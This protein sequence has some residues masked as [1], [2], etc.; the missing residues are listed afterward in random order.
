M[1]TTSP[2]RLTIRA[3]LTLL[4]SG[5]LFA[6]GA[7]QLAAMY[8]IVRNSL[9]RGFPPDI[10][11]ADAFPRLQ[12]PPEVLTY[13]DGYRNG[14][15]RD[16]ITQSAIA[17][18]LIGVIASALGWWLA[19]RALAPIHQIATTA[20]RVSSGAL[21]ERIRLEGPRDELKEL[22]DT[23]D[24]M[25]D[26]LEHAFTSQQRFVAN[27]S[28]ELRTP[29]ATERAILE[30]ALAEPSASKDLRH[31][32]TQLLNVHTRS[33]R[34]IDG[35]LTLA[36]GDQ[37]HTLQPVD[38]ADLAASAAAVCGAEAAASEITVTT[39][40]EPAL[41]TGD[42]DLLDRLVTN[43]VQNAIRYNEPGG[44]VAV[45]TK[46]NR[47]Q[48]GQPQAELVVENTGLPVDQDDL[49][50][51]FEPFRRG[52]DRTGDGVGLGL[53]IVKAITTAHGGNVNAHSRPNDGGLLVT[54][55]MPSHE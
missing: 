38:L 28:H 9:S 15:L 51:L 33:E 55:A 20:E 35:L 43:L 40:L 25:L 24:A 37:P 22:A 18:V 4:Y 34:L 39:N 10:P 13:I 17:L 53:S 44:W 14:I 52:Q 16:L 1:N 3:R 11:G 31:I 30:V 47:Q 2:T 42:P 21:T 27:A 23:F 26:R 54:V 19:G 6:A 46:T 32:G 12:I 45:S 29:L 36:R 7:L 49:N 41:L 5:A 48:P 8:A 50:D